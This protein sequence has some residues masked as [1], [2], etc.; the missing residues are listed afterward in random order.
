MA[1]QSH[2]WAEI[3]DRLL[4][5][6]E[7]KPFWDQV[8]AL[9]AF[10]ETLYLWNLCTGRWRIRTTLLTAANQYLYTLPA[11]M[12]HH[13]RVEWNRQPL[14]PSN[15]EDFNNG[16]YQWRTETTA[17]GGGVPAK[18]TVWAPV[19]LLTFYI[20]PADAANGN[21]LTI[22]GVSATPVLVNDGSFLDLG[23]E[24][25]DIL[26]GMALHV[27]AFKKGGGYFAA[28]Q[29][30][31]QAFL[32]AAAEENDQIKTAD[33]YRRVMGLDDRG[34]KIFRG[35]PTQIDALSGRQP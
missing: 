28:T 24:Q 11:T 32:A 8:E 31:F 7:R 3:R 22:D 5:R 33:S 18:P 15:R 34:F 12:L 9:A 25:L 14:S 2:T 27:L 4:D 26:L 13:M 21:T 29:S 17:T 10:N 35:L 30:L 16:R 23:E 19:S 20:W 1:Y 6:V